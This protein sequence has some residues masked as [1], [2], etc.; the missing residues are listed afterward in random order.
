YIFWRKEGEALEGAG[1]L[2][3]N[4]GPERTEALRV[5]LGLDDG[6]AAF[7][8]AGDPK[9]FGSF[10]GAARTRAGEDLNLVDRDQ[11]KL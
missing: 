7:F 4:I 10:A 2:A 8:G 11:F 5:Q 6:D 9:K 1:P 3:K